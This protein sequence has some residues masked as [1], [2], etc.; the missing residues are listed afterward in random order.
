MKGVPKYVTGRWCPVVLR[1]EIS[2]S[3]IKIVVV[4]RAVYLIDEDDRDRL[5]G[6]SHVLDRV[7][8]HHH[9]SAEVFLPSLSALPLLRIISKTLYSSTTSLHLGVFPGKYP[10]MA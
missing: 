6:V 3:F 4:S 5:L 1:L 2:A 7:L 10:V 9:I 8:S